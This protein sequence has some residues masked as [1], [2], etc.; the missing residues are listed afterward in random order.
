MRV[1]FTGTQE[2]MKVK[3]AKKLKKVLLDLMRHMVNEFH[4]GDCIGADEEA[5]EIVSRD[6]GCEIV[7][8]PPKNNSKRAWCKA[9][10]VRFREQKEYLARN[11]DIVDST[12]ILV[13]CP[14]GPEEI[15]SG[16]WST[17]R[18]AKKR[19][20]RVLVI[21]PDGETYYYD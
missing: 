4:H 15:R 1:G 20:K 12:E 11:K 16:T 7:I 13:A 9:G 3:Q 10:Q 19:G 17:V 2:G 21:K 8:H 6:I 14:K 5:H 18:Y